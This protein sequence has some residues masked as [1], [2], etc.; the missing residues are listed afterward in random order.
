M[1]SLKTES[2]HLLDEAPV[3][4]PARGLGA[5]GS[6]LVN[7]EEGGEDRRRRRYP[8]QLTKDSAG[9][10][11]VEHRFETM[12]VL[13]IVRILFIGG[14][15]AFVLSGEIFD[16]KV[17]SAPC[18]SPLGPGES[19]TGLRIPRWLFGTDVRRAE[20][21]PPFAEWRPGE[22]V[23]FTTEGVIEAGALV[24]RRKGSS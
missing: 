7:P 10:W 2:L 24:C 1:D 14:E 6:G 22:V 8:V 4:V 19:V 12:G 16:P 3:L 23:R 15:D 11:S 13:E 5:R 17:P 9:R 21:Q 20:L 18:R